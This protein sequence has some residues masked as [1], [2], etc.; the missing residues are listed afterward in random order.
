[1]YESNCTRLS[2]AD[3][4]SV[5]FDVASIA[6]TDVHSYLSWHWNGTCV[7]SHSR[8]VTTDQHGSTGWR[9]IS[10]S[11][12][13]GYDCTKAFTRDYVH[14]K[15]SIFCAGIDTDVYYSPNGVV[16]G[17]T[18]YVT[19]WRHDSTASGGCTALMHFVWYK[20]SY[21]NVV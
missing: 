11:N 10:K 4:E 6:L 17:P 14:F 1:M 9:L 12:Q 5:W 8:S 7:T 20:H 13:H 21:R 2:L 19:T 18:G 3:I 15:N 16:G